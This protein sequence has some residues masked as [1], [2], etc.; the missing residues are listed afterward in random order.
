MCGRN[1]FLTSPA[2]P[3]SMFFLL[4]LA[5]GAQAHRLD[6]QAFLT[7]NKLQVEAWFS[8]GEPARGAK[9]EI[10]GA[11]DRLLGEGK[12]NEKGVFVYTLEKPEALRIVV[13]AGLEHRKELRISEAQMG[14]TSVDPI[15]LADRSS[16]VP[17]KDILIGISFL[18]ALAAFFLNYRSARKIRILESRL[19]VA[20][21][22]T[23]V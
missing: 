11:G 14:Q 2:L 1:A 23:K 3:V 15:P 17:W 18:L 5:G 13:T 21:K 9:V 16:N 6:A 7:G 20:E 22:C 8:S 10:R 4:S 19:R 12:M